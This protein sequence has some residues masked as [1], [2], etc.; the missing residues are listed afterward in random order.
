[1]ERNKNKLSPREAKQSS[2][3]RKISHVLRAD[4]A[5]CVFGLSQPFFQ[6]LGKSMRPVGFG[7]I[8]IKKT[9]FAMQNMYAACVFP[10]AA[11]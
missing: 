5:V 9:R 3:K 6:V 7:G 8:N 1:M 11:C 4:E 2:R 10:G